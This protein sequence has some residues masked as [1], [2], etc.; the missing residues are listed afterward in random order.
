MLFGDYTRFNTNLF[1]QNDS[2]VLIKV[3]YRRILCDCKFMS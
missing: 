1:T 3:F 2:D